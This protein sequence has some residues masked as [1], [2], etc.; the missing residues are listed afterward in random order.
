MKAVFFLVALLWLSGTR[1]IAAISIGNTPEWLAHEA[2][3]II[4]GVPQHAEVRHLVGDRWLTTV[5]FRIS[6]RFKG[7]LTAG[8]LV[9]VTSIDSKGQT[10]QMD[11]AKAVTKK[12]SVLVLA[13]AAENTFP[14]TDGLYIFV[15]HFWNRPVFY[16]DEP[17][18]Y[19]YTE[20]GASIQAYAELRQRMEAQI[21]REVALIHRNWPGTIVKRQIGA[22]Y[23]TD[24][25]KQLYA[26]S[27]VLI[28]TVEYR[29]P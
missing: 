23:G 14:E 21:A 5:Q 19:I 25:Q 27:A 2:A 8:D 28:D 22:E 29:E 18:K 12:R 7:P 26:G 15:A 4:E 10:D 17:V 3:L 16:A 1:L 24:A 9:T 13:T 6:K 11:L 20:A